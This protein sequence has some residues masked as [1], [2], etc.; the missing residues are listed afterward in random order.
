MTIPSAR[1]NE[2][3][4]FMANPFTKEND[5]YDLQRFVAAQNAVYNDVVN[6]LQ[7]GK[8]QSHWMWFIFPQLAGLGHSS[9]AQYYA[10]SHMAEAVAYLADETLGP[11]L[12]A[13][14]GILLHHH[15][16]TAEEIFGPN[17]ARKL[18]SCMTLFSTASPR[19]KIFQQV[20][21]HYFAGK[22]D[23]LTLQLLERER[24][25]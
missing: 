24:R 1:T 25:D 22:K 3:H 20:L 4:L 6:E 5:P 7:S 11:R 16:K 17:D 9:T 13:C 21:D 15:Y 2:R 12:A 8:K 18:C 10:I 23:Q 14:S 19:D